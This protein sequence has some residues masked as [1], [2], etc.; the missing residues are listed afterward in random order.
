[1]KAKK[2]T[3]NGTYSFMRFPV[4]VL[5]ATF[6]GSEGLNWQACL[7]CVGPCWPNPWKNK[8]TGFTASALVANM[9]HAISITTTARILLTA[10]RKLANEPAAG[11]I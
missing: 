2:L 4:S 9:A 8:Q 6:S 10:W 5:Q 11:C 1:M 3:P 7:G